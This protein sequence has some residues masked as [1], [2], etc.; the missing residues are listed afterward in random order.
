HR[1]RPLFPTRRSSD[2]SVYRRLLVHVGC[3][4]GDLE[5]MVE[6]DGVEGAL[7]SLYR[8]GVYATA[9]EI[10]GRHPMRRGSLALETTPASFLNPRSE[11]H[12][13]ELQSLTNL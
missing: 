6:S 10:K 12:T 2:L 13:S 4:P 5:R 7:T 11:E 8:A 9:D 3:E 1:D